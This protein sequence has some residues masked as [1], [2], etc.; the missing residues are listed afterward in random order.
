M[1]LEG[2]KNFVYVFT[3]NLNYLIEIKVVLNALGCV[4]GNQVSFPDE[5]DLIAPFRFLHVVS[6]YKKC[7]AVSGEIIEKIPHNSSRDRINTC[8]GFI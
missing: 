2:L 4:I 5:T 1:S 8:S 7:H 6:G 3:V